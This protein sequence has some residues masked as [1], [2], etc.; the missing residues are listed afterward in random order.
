MP[1]DVWKPERRTRLFL[2]QARLSL[3]GCIAQTTQLLFWWTIYFYCSNLPPTKCYPVLSYHL[4]CT[5][6]ECFN[7]PNTCVHQLNACWNSVHRRIFDFKSWESVRE[8][9]RCLNSSI[10]ITRKS[11]A[12]CP[13]WC[14][15]IILLLL[16]LSEF[17]FVHWSIVNF[18][19]LHT[20][21]LV[22]CQM[23]IS[24]LATDLSCLCEI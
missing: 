4:V 21:L 10:C 18:V 23:R 17:L 9:I 5:A 14:V 2:M 6:L 3:R 16:Q 12:F 1:A 19:N 20:Y 15:V 7:F 22:I 13:V 11:C 24:S 8:L